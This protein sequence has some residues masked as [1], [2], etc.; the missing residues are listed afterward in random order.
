MGSLNVFTYG[1]PLPSRQVKISLVKILDS[2][3]LFISSVFQLL[4]DAHCT[5]PIL[6]SNNFK[7]LHCNEKSQQQNVT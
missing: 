2:D 1:F 7:S 5:H 3:V 4:S 6:Q